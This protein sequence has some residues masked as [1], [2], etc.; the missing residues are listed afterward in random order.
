MAI[1][2]FNII[3]FFPHVIGKVYYTAIV[4]QTMEHHITYSLKSNYF[5][6]KF[7]HERIVRV[8]TVHHSAAQKWEWGR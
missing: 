2:Y 8:R 5:I 3:Q 1:I 7:S 4:M 6:G